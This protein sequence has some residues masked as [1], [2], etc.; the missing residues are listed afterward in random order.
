[1]KGLLIVDG[2]KWT[3]KKKSRYQRE[4][5][6]GKSSVRQDDFDVPLL[7][8]CVF[9]LF[10]VSFFAIFSESYPFISSLFPCLSVCSTSKPLAVGGTFSVL[11]PQCKI[12]GLKDVSPLFFSLSSFSAF[13][14][15]LPPFVRVGAAYLAVCM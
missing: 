10:F 3:T 14:S 12:N 15:L 9:S 1:M 6:N 2:W 7:C 11:R 13:C 5:I 8:F 4:K